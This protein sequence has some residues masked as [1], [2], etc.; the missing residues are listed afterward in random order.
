MRPGIVGRKFFRRAA[1][2][3]GM[4]GENRAAWKKATWSAGGDEMTARCMLLS[5]G[6]GNPGGGLSWRF[7]SLVVGHRVP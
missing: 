2:R 3:V 5:V 1:A 4:L 6:E 7:Q